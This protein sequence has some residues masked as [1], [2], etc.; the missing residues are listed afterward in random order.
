MTCVLKRAR[1]RTS[2]TRVK[3]RTTEI[4]KITAGVLIDQEILP[5]FFVMMRSDSRPRM[6]F[7][8]TCP[9]DTGAA[10][11]IFLISSMTSAIFDFGTGEVRR[12][13]ARGS[14][15]PIKRTEE[16]TLRIGFVISP[17]A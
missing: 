6:F 3:E 5:I 1:Y 10:T 7:T 12:T 14:T 13:L 9:I 4:T 11:E 16:L 2:T 15:P 17:A 8:M